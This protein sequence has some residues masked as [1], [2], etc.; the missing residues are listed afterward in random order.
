[1]LDGAPQIAVPTF[2]ST[3]SICIV[4]VPV[5]LLTGTAQFL[6]T[7]LAMA[8][9]FAML[10]SYL[11][12]RTLVPTMVHY[13]LGSEVELVHRP[14]G[15]R[16]AQACS[17]ELHHGFNA[18]VR[19]A[20][21]PLH[22]AA[23]LVAATIAAWCS[24]VFVAVRIGSLV[25]VALIGRDFF[26]TSMP[27]R[28]GCTRARRRAPHRGD[29]SALRRH[30]AGDPPRDP[31][32]ELDTHLDNIGIPNGGAASRRATSRPSRRPTARS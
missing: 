24:R 4:F 6:F 1:M 13:L 28:C 26:P 30:R 5:L 31:A 3:L 16:P 23:R 10:A 29:R 21:L 17:A 25:L 32:G 9:V 27:G 19:A 18:A 22:R 15:A 7:P 2:V 8:V 12:S 20:S 11:L 14:D